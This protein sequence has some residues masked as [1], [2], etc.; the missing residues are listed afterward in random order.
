MLRDDKPQKITTLAGN[1]PNSNTKVKDWKG[2]V[3]ILRDIPPWLLQLAIMIR[4][5]LNAVTPRIVTG[6][7]RSRNIEIDRSTGR[8][9][10]GNNGTVGMAG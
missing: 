7:T 5:V 8:R 3:Q 6:G 4:T 1:L 9:M 2:Q 10:P